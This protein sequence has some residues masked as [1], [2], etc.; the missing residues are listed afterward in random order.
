MA[1]STEEAVSWPSAASGR[2][3]RRPRITNSEG[4]SVYVQQSHFVAANSRGFIGGYPFSRHTLS[5]AP[6]A[7]KGNKM[8]RDDWYTSAR[9]PSKL[10]IAGSRRPLRRRA[11]AG[12]PE[13]AQARY[14]HLPG[15]VRG[16]AGGRPAR[17]FRAGRVGRR[18]VPQVELPARFAGQIGFPLA[19]PDRGRPARDRRVGSSPFDE[20]GVR[21]SAARWSGRRAAGLFPV[22]VFGA[23][24]GHANHR[25]R[26]R[27]AQPDD[28][29]DR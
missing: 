22:L 27:L 6:I 15:A 21:T 9:D 17:R 10:A 26:R 4:A 18:A 13:R 29:V 20:E 24:A 16:A 7:G 12:A 28:H 19:H 25:Q 1:D 5:V 11:R 3:R 14:P 2:L 23:Q 8:Q